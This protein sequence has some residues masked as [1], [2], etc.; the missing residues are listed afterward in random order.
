MAVIKRADAET[1]TRQAIV[2]DLGDLARQGER[3]RQEAASDA[4][5]IRLEAEAHRRKLIRGAEDEGRKEGLARGLAEGRE[6]GREEGRAQAL[7]E[8]QERLATLEAAWAAGLDELNA[9]R[10]ALLAS[11]RTEALRLALDIAERI[12]RRQVEIDPGAVEGPI[13]A[14][15]ELISVGTRA[16][17]CVHPEDEAAAKEALPKLSARLDAAQHAEVRAEASIAR[18]GCVV[19]TPGGA[20]VDADIETQIAR[21]VGALRAGA[22]IGPRADA[23]SIDDG[24]G[25]AA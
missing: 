10:G 5:K 19:R 23:S 2:L 25:G 18:G 8:M 9:A 13:A 12:T 14:A 3:M 11:A 20:V 17:V 24:E 15:L 1:M 6:Q 22:G 4:Q 21:V 7:A 16:V